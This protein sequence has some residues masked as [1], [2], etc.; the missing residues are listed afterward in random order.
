MELHITNTGGVKYNYDGRMDPVSDSSYHYL[1]TNSG[2]SNGKA[3]KF[4]A[5]YTRSHSIASTP[6]NVKLGLKVDDPL[7]EDPTGYSGSPAW[8]YRKIKPSSD[9]NYSEYRPGLVSL[10][11][12]NDIIHVDNFRLIPRSPYYKYD[13]MNGSFDN[14]VSYCYLESASIPADLT[15]SEAGD[16]IENWGTVSGTVTIPATADYDS[17]FVF[18]KTNK[19]V[20]ND[21]LSPTIGKVVGSASV[22]RLQFRACFESNHVTYEPGLDSS[23][24]INMGGRDYSK[25]SGKNDNMNDTDEFNFTET[26][27]L[28][29]ITVTYLPTTEVMYWKKEK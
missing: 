13:K 15:D 28:E 4:A 14:Y 22:D 10:V 3:I 23:Q 11:A 25:V 20:Y 1:G 29:D 26:P 27:V 9:V 8:R 7:E 24:N 18:F 5:C 12:Y 19:D 21:N 6:P 16:L 2:T 17:E